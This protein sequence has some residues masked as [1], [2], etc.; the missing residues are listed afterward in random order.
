MAEPFGRAIRECYHDEQSESLV[1]FDGDH[2]LDHPIE[3]FYFSRPIS[4]D[5]DSWT[6]PYLS[7]P[8][9]DVGAGAGQDALYYQQQFETVAIEVSDHLVE[10]MD[11]RGVEDARH[12]DMFALPEQ[13]GTD[14]FASVLVRGTQLSLAKSMQGIEQFLADLATVT[15]PDATAVVDGYD[16]RDEDVRDL[17]GYRADATPGLAFRVFALEYEGS[18]GE[19]L[20]FRL[21][22]PE[23]LREAAAETPWSI[24]AVNQRSESAYYLAALEKE[25]AT[26]RYC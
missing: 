19:T 9:L 20:L 25:V 10:L 24:S 26:G 5:R 18:V 17:L 7:G 15:T 22:S 23:R 4:G 11:E 2:R 1:Q 16:P 14:R 21:V 8:L 6:E 12:G 3:Q 13:F